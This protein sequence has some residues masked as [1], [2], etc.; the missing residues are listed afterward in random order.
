MILNYYAFIISFIIG[1]FCVYM[2]IPKQKVIMVYPT[3]DNLNKM[4]YKDYSDNCFGFEAK[5]VQCPSDK[6]KIEEYPVQH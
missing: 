3:I 1:V 4:A 6:S 5:K 2:V